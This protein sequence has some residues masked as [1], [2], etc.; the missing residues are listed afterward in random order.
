MDAVSLIIDGVGCVLAFTILAGLLLLLLS[1][2][3]WLEY[4]QAWRRGAFLGWDEAR[5]RVLAGHG[6]I[7]RVFDYN[8]SRTTYWWIDRWPRFP[9]PKED[10]GTI[11]PAEDGQWADTP[12]SELVDVYGLLASSGYYL[13]GVPAESELPPF[14][15]AGRPTGFYL[16]E[17]D[18][19]CGGCDDD[20]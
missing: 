9:S 2:T 20:D 11:Q 1:L 17:D 7:L 16:I 19:E 8:N 18:D 4:L 14:D 3:G 15:D 6:S 5:Q 12:F 10:A 13:T